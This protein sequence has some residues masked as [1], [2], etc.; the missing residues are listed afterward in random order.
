MLAHMH[1]ALKGE[2]LRIW[3]CLITALVLSLLWFGSC[4]G[5]RASSAEPK[6]SEPSGHELTQA[7]KQVEHVLARLQEAAGKVQPITE[8][9]VVTTFPK[10]LFFSVVFPQFPRARLI[11]GPLRSGNV[12]AV[13]RDRGGQLHLFTDT[14]G[15][16]AF[17]RSTLGRIQDDNTA[18]DV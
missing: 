15:L 9:P 13:P 10:Y 16:E 14:Q 1:I 3:A 6:V 7:R 17:F 2:P 4:V 8:D 18:K 11:P 12:Y 5:V